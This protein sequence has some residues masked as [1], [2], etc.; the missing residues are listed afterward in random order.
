MTLVDLVEM[1][2]DWIASCTRH[3]NGNPFDSIVIN[4]ERFG[5]DDVMAQILANTV[6]KLFPELATKCGTYEEAVLRKEEKS[7]K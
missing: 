7:K 5:Y 1:F 6:T 4:K 3:D 2:C